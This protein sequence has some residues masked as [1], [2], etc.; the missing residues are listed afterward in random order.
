MRRACALTAP[1]CIDELIRRGRTLHRIAGLTRVT[2]PVVRAW[3]AGGADPSEAA[4]L[5]LLAVARTFTA[6]VPFQEEEPLASPI[7]GS[8][9]SRAEV[10]Q[11]VAMLERAG[12]GPDR[13]SQR[14]GVSRQTVISWRRG[15]HGSDAKRGASLSALLNVVQAQ[16]PRSSPAPHGTVRLAV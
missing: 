2:V 6:L 13:I 8:A 10:Q 15:A 9:M 3:H 16:A 4:F 12:M 5:R 14:L 7:S 11:A 1:Q